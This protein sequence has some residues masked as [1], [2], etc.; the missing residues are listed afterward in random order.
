M[1]E[2][3][4]SYLLLFSAILA[5]SL[6]TAGFVFSLQKTAGAVN[7]FVLFC[8]QSSGKMLG[9]L[10]HYE[11]FWSLIL[12]AIFGFSLLFGF[13]NVLKQIFLNCKLQLFLKKLDTNEI[14]FGQSCYRVVDNKK[15]FAITVGF[16]KPIVYISSSAV[17]LLSSNEQKAV[18]SHEFFHQKNNHPLIKLIVLFLGKVFFFLP[19]FPALSKHVLLRIETSADEYAVKIAGKKAVGSALLKFYHHAPQMNFSYASSFS[20]TDDRIYHFIYNY[21]PRKFPWILLAVSIA[22]LFFLSVFLAKPIS[23]KTLSA[24]H[25]TGVECPGPK[26]SIISLMSF[27]QVT[28]NLSTEAGRMY[29][30]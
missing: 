30:Q 15:F 8:T 22:M 19:F 25:L 27:G 1:K 20:A 24:T 3:I 13:F 9:F 4:Y 11:N 7:S 23:G 17:N 18:L 16:L 14:T 10:L 5:V 2:K 21:S 6:A 12:T 29:S 26:E 28:V